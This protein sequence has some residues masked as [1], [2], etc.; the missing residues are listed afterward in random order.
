MADISTAIQGLNDEAQA[1]YAAALQALEDGDLE[2]AT[3]A[4]EAAEAANAKAT[5]MESER[6]KLTQM[7][8]AWKEKVNTPP[9]SRQ[10]AEDWG[11]NGQEQGTRLH[12]SYRPR[13]WDDAAPAAA[14]PAAVQKHM[15]EVQKEEARLYTDGFT[16]LVRCGMDL[17]R[18]AN[19]AKDARMVQVISEATDAAG[20]V[21]VPEEL[22]EHAAYAVHDPGQR[23]ARFREACTVVP[24]GSDKGN[25][26]TFA[27]VSFYNLGETATDAH[28]K[29]SPYTEQTPTAGEVS[30]DINKHGLRSVVSRES[31]DDSVLDI[32][33]MLSR[34]YGESYLRFLSEKFIS[35]TG[36]NE[37]TGLRQGTSITRVAA[38]AAAGGD[39]TPSRILSLL[40]DDAGAFTRT[41]LDFTEALAVTSLAERRSDNQFGQILAGLEAAYE[42]LPEG[43][44]PEFAEQAIR[45]QLL[46]GVPLEE[47]VG[48]GNVGTFRALQEGG[49]LSLL[50]LF[51]A[52]A[53]L[54]PT[55]DDGLIYQIAAAPALAA[56]AQR[57]VAAGAGPLDV[58]DRLLE[59]GGRTLGEFATG[60]VRG[61]LGGYA[62]FASTIYGETILG[63]IP[64]SGVPLGDLYSFAERAGGWLGGLLGGGDDDA[65]PGVLPRSEREPQFIQQPQVVFNAPVYAPSQAV[66]E[67]IV[68]RSVNR[69]I[70][71]GRIATDSDTARVYAQ[72]GEHPVPIIG[73]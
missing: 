70:N 67:D 68:T 22:R 37:P 36:T 35:G 56:Q 42:N 65:R 10:D 50:R 29:D 23:P 26:P 34:V 53:G 16:E 19:T 31:L 39:T 14:Q 13:G 49:G 61:A 25:V 33:M 18:F 27:D 73:N 55:P 17:A 21:W 6:A 32:P 28:A 43:T 66:F 58:V 71:D 45:S 8:E 72:T 62:D 12:N 9:R 15:G 64:V 4:R 59:T 1:H 54:P 48:E 38:S 46:Q 60:D 44:P 41:G 51:D 5:N 63:D 2:K 30:F 20:A 52:Q 57:G 7:S 40:E 47:I 3:N 24:V 11:K 69:A